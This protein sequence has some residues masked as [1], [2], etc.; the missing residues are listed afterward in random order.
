MHVYNL[1][2]KIALKVKFKVTKIKP[3]NDFSS[4]FNSNYTPNLHCFEVIA[5]S[6]CTHIHLGS[7]IAINVKLNVTTMKTVYKF[8]S[9]FN[10]NHQPYLNNSYVIAN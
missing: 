5:I 9:V 4:M 8:L 1:T 7:K 6:K 3:M 10:S 2:L